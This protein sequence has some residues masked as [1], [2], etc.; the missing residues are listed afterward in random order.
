MVIK[1]KTKGWVYTPTPKPWEFLT[2][3]NFKSL[4]LLSTIGLLAFGSTGA[5]AADG[6]QNDLAAKYPASYPDYVGVDVNASA[7]VAG[8]EQLSGDGLQG[9][10]PSV[11]STLDAQTEAFIKDNARIE[12][13]RAVVPFDPVAENVPPMEDR[14]GYFKVDGGSELTVGKGHR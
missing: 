14:P 5:M 7:S 3:P 9:L 13:S 1:D 12:D 11:G 8:E 6:S 4:A 2:I 10:S